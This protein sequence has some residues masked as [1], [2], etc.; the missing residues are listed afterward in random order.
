MLIELGLSNVG[1]AFLAG[2]ALLS[3]FSSLPFAAPPSYLSLTTIEG[4]QRSGKAKE[5]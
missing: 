5:T 4:Q 1:Q 2:Q 3:N